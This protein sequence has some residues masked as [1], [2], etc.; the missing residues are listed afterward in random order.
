MKNH[1]QTLIITTAVC[2]TAWSGPRAQAQEHFKNRYSIGVGFSPEWQLGGLADGKFS[3]SYGLSFEAQFSRHS[4]MEF[5]IGDRRFAYADKIY[6]PGGNM[7]AYKLLKYNIHYVSLR[8]GYKYYS[9]ILNFSAGFNVDF[10]VSTP[11]NGVYSSGYLNNFDRYGFYVTISKDIP[12]YK[13]LILEP[14]VHVNPFL[15][16][17]GKEVKTTDYE[18][19]FLGMGIKLKYRF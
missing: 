16:D 4:G 18:G 10:A 12:L 17:Q 15:S 19:M 2:L 6:S 14:E 8:L 3:P 7:Q 5:G 13:G 1:I 11:K 9:D